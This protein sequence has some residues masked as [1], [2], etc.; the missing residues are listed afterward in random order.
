M[1][2]IYNLE[3]FASGGGLGMIESRLY[4]S[5]VTE[6]IKRLISQTRAAASSRLIYRV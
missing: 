1:T 6:V 4:V 2:R 5:H 3:Y